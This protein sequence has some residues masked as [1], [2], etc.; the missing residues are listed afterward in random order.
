MQLNMKYLFDDMYNG[1][2]VK[3]CDISGHSHFI[4]FTCKLFPFSLGGGRRERRQ[5]F[6]CL[7]VWFPFFYLPLTSFQPGR[8]ICRSLESRHLSSDPHPVLP[9]S[10]HT[11]NLLFVF[12][13]HLSRAL[14]PLIFS[15]PPLRL[16]GLASKITRGRED[17]KPSSP[18]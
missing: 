4:V 18:V 11:I 14:S 6:E 3:N 17:G 2:I 1:K 7:S 8:T 13:K 10:L 12:A 16:C 15:P 5:L 9:I